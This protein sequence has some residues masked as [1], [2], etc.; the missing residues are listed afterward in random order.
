MAPYEALYGRRC[1]TPLCWYQDGEN[2][3]VGPELVQQTTEKVK[4]IREKM[5]ASQSRQK[6]YADVR[7]KDL[8]FEAGDHVF[9]RVTQTTGVGRA[10][11]SKK[12]TPKFIGPYQIIE[13]VGPVAYRIAL[14]PFLSNIHDVLHVSQLR[15]YV[16]DPSHVIEPDHL[17][18]KDNLTV[19]VPPMKI[20]ERRIKQLRN[21]QVSLVKVIWNQTTRDATWELE[22][23]MREQYPELFVDP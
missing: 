2:L 4:Q 7:R 23:K 8:E 22:D 10:M 6:S 18:L 5:R 1:R 17:Q 9:L 15:K 19:E 3:I 12:L 20:E 14:P 13:R 11:K 16:S 21:K